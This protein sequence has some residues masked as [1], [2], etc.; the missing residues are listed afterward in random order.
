MPELDSMLLR[1]SIGSLTSAG[2][3]CAGCRRTPLTGERLHELDTGRM[4]CDLCLAAVPED[5]RRTVRSQRVRAS[6]RQLPIAPK[7]A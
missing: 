5:D 1:K 6:E 4:L 3:P 7:A 2:A